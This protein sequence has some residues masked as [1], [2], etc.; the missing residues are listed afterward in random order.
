MTNGHVSPPDPSEVLRLGIKA[1]EE[2]I[3]SNECLPQLVEE[4]ILQTERAQNRVY[5]IKLSLLQRPSTTEYFGELYVDRDYKEGQRNGAS[6]RY[7]I[8]LRR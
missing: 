5:H 3:Q 6:C 4:Y 7:I 1:C 8:N 2:P